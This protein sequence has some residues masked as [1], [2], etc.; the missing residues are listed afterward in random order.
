MEDWTLL[1]GA[2]TKH[3]DR[4]LIIADNV[5]LDVQ[6][7]RFPM[8][9]CNRV[10]HAHQLKL[11]IEADDL[12]VGLLAGAE[13]KENRKKTTDDAC[14]GRLDVLIC[15]DKIAGEGLDIPPVDT[16]HIVF[17][18]NNEANL[19]QYTGRGRRKYQDKEYC[20]LKVYRDFI[21]FERMKHRTEHK[22]GERIFKNQTEWFKK[23]KFK[24]FGYTQR[25]S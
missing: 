4:N 5:V 15:M 11:L 3:H 24:V 20:L 2:V 13:N 6:S 18:M 17:P 16:I 9:L 12:R 14:S 7:G 23:W 25:M 21:Y 19:K 1:V 22:L 10:Q 8:V